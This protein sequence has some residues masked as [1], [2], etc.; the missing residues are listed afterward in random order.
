MGV[1]LVCTAQ[2]LPLSLTSTVMDPCHIGPPL[3]VS[4]SWAPPLVG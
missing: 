3:P 4:T 2:H 1:L